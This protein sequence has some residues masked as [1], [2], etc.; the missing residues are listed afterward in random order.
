MKNMLTSREKSLTDVQL[1]EMSDEK[2]RELDQRNHGGASIVLTNRFKA[3]NFI[4]LTAAQVYGNSTTMT[5]SSWAIIPCITDVG[6]LGFLNIADGTAFDST[7][8][9]IPECEDLG[10]RSVENLCVGANN[11]AVMIES[12]D[13]S[14]ESPQKISP[15]A[16][17]P[18]G[19]RQIELPTWRG[20]M[21]NGHCKVP[22]EFYKGK[23]IRPKLVCFGLI[24]CYG[25][26]GKPRQTLYDDADDQTRRSD[27]LPEWITHGFERPDPSWWTWSK[28]QHKRVLELVSAWFLEISK[29]LA[30]H[31]E[32]SEFCLKEPTEANFK[33]L[34][35]LCSLAE[36]KD[37]GDYW[38]LS[39]VE[40][41]LLDMRWEN[42]RCQVVAAV[43]R[44]WIGKIQSA[45][46]CRR[47]VGDISLSLLRRVIFRKL[48][49]HVDALRWM[50][51][52]LSQVSLS[53][54][55][56]EE[57]ERACPFHETIWKLTE[58]ITAYF[59]LPILDS[60]K[61]LI[62]EKLVPILYENGPVYVK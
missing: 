43:D 25:E 10:Y 37:Q 32:N 19:W 57:R 27:D 7:V 59:C 50:V 48:K 21:G 13:N 29:G 58:N 53:N 22:E 4:R 44:F 55:A 11:A 9:C 34:N 46:R 8:E 31:L 49:P 15:N 54:M 39:R 33:E 14:P 52:G 2:L 18:V 28:D 26:P 5:F 17:M 20:Y 1:R 40:R 56:R 23:M 38:S 6:N 30:V 41:D 42:T 51:E 12:I 3:A 35:R 16:A 36:G 45:V 47:P 60:A 61:K 24:T 62:N